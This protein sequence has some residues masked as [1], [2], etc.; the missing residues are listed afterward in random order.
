[1]NQGKIKNGKVTF[2][3][4]NNGQHINHWENYI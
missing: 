1:M 4:L 2:F 3:S